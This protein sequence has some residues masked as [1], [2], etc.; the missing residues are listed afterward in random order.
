MGRQTDSDTPDG[1]S[2]GGKLVGLGIYLEGNIRWG[3]GNCSHNPKCTCSIQ[4]PGNETYGEK[5]ARYR[6]FFDNGPLMRC[7]DQEEDKKL[8]RDV[9]FNTLLT[10]VQQRPLNNKNYRGVVQIRSFWEDV[11]KQLRIED[12]EGCTSRTDGSLNQNAL[13][14]PKASKLAAQETRIPNHSQEQQSTN[15]VHNGSFFCGGRA[16]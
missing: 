1:T 9:L 3:E 7:L 13:N 4:R 10:D 6:E 11:R 2:E 16:A 12:E 5:L 14:L 8:A 15:P